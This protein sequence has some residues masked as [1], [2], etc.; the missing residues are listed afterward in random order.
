MHSSTLLLPS[1]S[2]PYP[3]THFKSRHLTT[4]IHTSWT[5]IHICQLPRDCKAPLILQLFTHLVNRSNGS[6]LP[7]GTINKLVSYNCKYERAQ[8]HTNKPLCFFLCSNTHS[9][10]TASISATTSTT[11]TAAP[12]ATAPRGIVRSRPITIRRY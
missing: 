6:C 7:G 9:T 12:P 4:I 10:A 1:P 11:T 3:N 8:Q 2:L 5:G